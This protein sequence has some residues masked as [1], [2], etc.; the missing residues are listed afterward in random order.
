MI[1]T[2]THNMMLLPKYGPREPFETERNG[3]TVFDTIYHT[4]PDFSFVNQEGTTITQEDFKGKIRVV[5]FFF[6]TCQSICPKMS[7]QFGRVQ[8]KFEEDDEVILLSHTVDPEQDDVARLKV[9]A[10]EYRAIPGKW[11]LVT[12]SKK[13]LYDIAR[14]GYFVTAE[15]GDGGEEDFIHSEQ[16]VLVDWD[17]VIRGYFD[18]TSYAD[19]NDLMNAI[20]VLKSE[21]FRP[22]KK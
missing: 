10:D 22:V 14:Y 5:D 8:I 18:G 11:H 19:M 17:G 2:G 7:S 20:N 4:V 6:T 3:K 15:E 21:K 16:V 13:E 9:Y 12:G 1:G